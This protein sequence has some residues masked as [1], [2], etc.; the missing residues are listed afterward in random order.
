MLQKQPSRD[1]IPESWDVSHDKGQFRNFMAE[2]HLWMQAWSDQDERIL[3]SVEGVDK[4]ERSILAVD[5]TEADF[6]TFETALYQISHRTTTH[7]PLRMVQQAQGQ[8]GFEASHMIVGRYDQ[9]NMSFRSSAYAALIS[10]ISERDRVKYV[11]QFDDI[12]KNFINET[13][14]YEPGFGKIRDEEKTLAVK[15]LMFES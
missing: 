13:N 4:V 8:S 11:E 5:C 7:E 14:K 15:K 6:R 12:L 1:L 2:L 3:V 9:R 10:N